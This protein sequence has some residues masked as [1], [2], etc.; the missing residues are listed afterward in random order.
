MRI[1]K[2]MMIIGVITFAGELCNLLLPLPV[3]ASVYGM[4]LLFLCLQ[5]GILKLSQVEDTADFLVAVMPVMFVAPCVSLMDTV[6]GVMD[7]IPALVIIALFT[8]IMTMSVTGVIAQWM[9]RLRRKSE[10]TDWDKG[11]DFCEI[12]DQR[13]INIENN[14]TDVSAAGNKDGNKD[15]NNR[16][17]QGTLRKGNVA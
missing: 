15:G 1:L 7:C 10:S 16:R 13:K 6:P 2:Q 12:A 8:T 3:P 11:A 14:Q 5:T 17:K 4:V 9:I